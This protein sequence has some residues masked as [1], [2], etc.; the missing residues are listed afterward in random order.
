L[1]H[2]QL[3]KYFPQA[4]P[5]FV[6]LEGF[7][8]AMVFVEGLKKAG[9][10]PTREKFIEGIESLHGTDLGLGP[11][12]KLNYSESSHKG[13]NE[14]YTTVVKGGKAELLNNW[15]EVKHEGF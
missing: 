9:S 2:D 11:K 5:N 10:N 12:L 14:V 3:A 8:D 4:K 1:Y 15:S 6:S 7:L 13:L